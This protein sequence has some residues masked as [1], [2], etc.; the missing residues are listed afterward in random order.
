[1]NFWAW[2]R[3]G[4]WALFFV[5]PLFA[6]EPIGIPWEH[7]WGVIPMMFVAGMGMPFLIC[8]T[9]RLEEKLFSGAQVWQRPSLSIN[10]FARR[11]PLQ[12]FWTAGVGFVIAA[13]SAAIGLFFHSAEHLKYALCLAAGGG[14]ILLGIR[15]CLSVFRIRFAEQEC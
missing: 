13:F 7:L 4:F 1:M 3:T 5:S 9:L 8:G 15:L 10:P 12:F 14:G 11:K 6:M 2:M